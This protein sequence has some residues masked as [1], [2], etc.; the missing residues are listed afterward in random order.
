MKRPTG[1]PPL[2]TPRGERIR[3][4]EI[5]AEPSAGP[6]LGGVRDPVG[7]NPAAGLT[8]ARLAVI[9]RG[10]AEGSWT[11]YLE[12]A[13]A[14]EE[15]DPH[16][17]AVL[18]VRKRS[19]AQLPITVEAVS[20]DP[21]HEEH[22]DFI[23]RWIK[24]GTL[25]KSLFDI[26]D[27][28]GKGFSVHEIEWE[29]TV[30]HFWPRALHYRP[31]RW[32]EADL[33]DRDTPR[34]REV[35]EL[36]DLPQHRFFL[37][38]HKAKSGSLIRSGVAY[39]AAWSWMMKRFSDHDWAVFVRNYGK[40][41]RVGKYPPLSLESDREV[42]WRA[43]ANIAGDTA[44]IIPEGMSIE[45]VSALEGGARS[46]LHQRRVDHIDQQVSK[47]VLGQTTTTDAISGGHAVSQE[48]REVAGDI[49]RADAL[50]LSSTIT[51]QLVPWLISLNFGP[52]ED[53]P[54]IAVGRPDEM[55]IKE[56][57]AAIKDLA[58][59]G[60]RVEVGQIYDRLGIEEP[61][62][63]AETIGGAPAAMSDPLAGLFNRAASLRTGAT[64]V[65]FE[66]LRSLMSSRPDPDLVEALA[67][68]TAEDAAGA[69]GGLTAAIR[70][71]FDAARDLDDLKERLAK[72]QLDPR[73]FAQAMARGLALSDLAGRAA[74]LEELERDDAGGGA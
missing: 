73:E 13:E 40:P 7:G 18:G 53:Y 35:G 17:Q 5:L 65:P 66:T 38:V 64:P 12:L 61:A 48:H 28:V 20:D 68:R 16:Y 49:E 24:R 41:L 29:T 43:V 9:L 74:L 14:M 55:P 1:L 8:P 2:V 62:E 6:T 54:V 25:R 46:D 26:L 70:A 32:F 42:L 37:H 39:M 23:R 69:L 34:L 47:L 45:F 11:E 51:E 52:Q 56:W 21:A 58:P 4:A 50:L 31:Q 60:L 59:L 44:A 3:R 36:L 57:V 19:V 15:R 10:A 71:E 63:D 33:I 27:A 22:A 67:R 72:L 30:D